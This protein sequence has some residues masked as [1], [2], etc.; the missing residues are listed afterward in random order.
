MSIRISTASKAVRVWAVV[1]L[2][3]ASLVGVAATGQAATATEAK[4]TLSPSTG[5][6]L[7]ATVLSITGTGFADSGGTPVATQVSYETTKTCPASPG[8]N[9]DTDPTVVSAT[10]MTSTVPDTLDLSAPGKAT[11]YH[12]CVYSATPTVLGGADF[13]LYPAPTVTKVAPAG[14][15]TAGGYTVTVVGTNFT[16]KTTATVGGLALTNLKVAKDGASF[17]ATVP[18]WT[19]TI[20]TAQDV[21]VSNEG[22]DSTAIS[23]DQFTFSNGVTISP[24]NGPS[25]GG[26][27]ISVKGAGFKTLAWP[28]ATSPTNGKAW[29]VF[30]SGQ[31]SALTDGSG[32]ML[33]PADFACA[34]VVV[35]GD[36]ELLC[37]TPTSTP[38]SATFVKGRAYTLTV[39]SDYEGTCTA[40]TGSN[41]TTK[42][43]SAGSNPSFISAVSSGST[44]TFGDF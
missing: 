40:W 22:G 41:C 39:I 19:G 36:T 34:K 33:S 20:G 35:I 43:A 1:G 7:T 16:A 15:M 31:Y 38:V 29:V 18:K 3:S 17:T 8:A 5:P 10:R 12:V 26:T 44:Y 2:A 11:V 32:T 6:A 21:I 37:T 13:T 30:T 4:A 23:T 9:L 27:V 28:G 14:G 24:Q 25:T 42:P